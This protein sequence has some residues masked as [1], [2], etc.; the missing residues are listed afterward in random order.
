MENI[1]V[2]WS[3]SETESNLSDDDA[4]QADINEMI[5]PPAKKRKISELL[6][7]WEGRKSGFH[8][9]FRCEDM[10]Q[11][12]KRVIDN[13]ANCVVCSEKTRYMCITCNAYCCISNKI[14]LNCFYR[15][16]KF[17]DFRSTI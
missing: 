17:K 11:N 16:H 4:E 15:L 14:P 2:Q 1:V 8:T 6:L 7:D 10:R 3:K 13:R 5:Q 9:P 12:K